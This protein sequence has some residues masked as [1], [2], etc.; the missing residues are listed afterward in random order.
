[1]R[2]F[3]HICLL[4][5]SLACDAAEHDTGAPGLSRIEFTVREIACLACAARIEARLG[6]LPGAEHVEVDLESKV[7]TV[8]FDAAL[9]DSARIEAAIAELGFTPR[10]VARDH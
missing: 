1:M 8:R 3:L 4:L 7:V 10:A 5:A 9:L 2:F 6:E